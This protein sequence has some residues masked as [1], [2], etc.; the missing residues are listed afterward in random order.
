MRIPYDSFKT[1]QLNRMKNLGFTE[2]IQNLI[3]P[4]IDYSELGR[5][6]IE[7]KERYT[8]QT[9]NVIYNAEITGNL[10]FS[11]ESRADYPAVGDWVRFMKM[12]DQNAIILEIFP[13]YSVLQ[14]QAVGKSTDVQIIASNIDYAFIMQSVGQDFNL[15]RLE[16]YL[17][18]CYSARIEPIVILTKI[19]L[20]GKDE[21]ETLILKIKERINTITVYALSNETL[22]GFDLLKQSMLPNSTY[23]FIGSSGVG[24]S[25]LVNRLKEKKVQKTSA[26]SESTNKGRHI[27]SHRELIVL[28]N[29]SIIIDT[30]GMREIGMTEQSNGIDATYDQISELAKQCRFA[31]CTH[32]NEIGCAVIKALENGGLTFAV[33]ENYL[34]LKREQEHFSAS[35]YEKRQK[36]KVFGKM[37]K[38]VKDQ[39]KRYKY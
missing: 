39:K 3:P 30:P 2:K 9:K 34:K 21:V 24:K 1:K 38:T 32:E 12:D 8:L 25:T 17:A 37:V 31:D 26:I 22:E 36:D 16:R 20:A 33:Y 10:R 29:K 27:T 19:D 13:R 35:V 28:S 23:C 7:H 15:N 18:I 4:D 5:I 11:A 14:R 6:I